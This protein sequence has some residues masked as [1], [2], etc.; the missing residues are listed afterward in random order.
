VELANLEKE[1]IFEAIQEHCEEI[2]EVIIPKLDADKR[3]CTLE[4]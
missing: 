3:D 2:V 1:E 4:I